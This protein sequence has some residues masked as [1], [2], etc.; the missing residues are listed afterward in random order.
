MHKSDYVKAQKIVKGKDVL[1]LGCNSGYGTNL[2]SQSCNRIVGVDVSPMALEVGNARYLRGNLSF[3]LVDGVSLPFGDQSFDV[4]TSFQVVEHLPEYSAYFNEIRRVLKP[5]GLLLLTTPNGAIRVNPGEKP[6][7]R[8]HVHEF[9]A[10]ELEELLHGYFPHV[11]VFGQFASERA[12]S[13]EFNRCVAA[14]DN[15]Y[16]TNST[17]FKSQIKKILPGSVADFFRTIRATSQSK[18]AGLVSDKFMAQFSI[19]DFSYGTSSLNESL[20]L[21]ACCAPSTEVLA[22]CTKIFCSGK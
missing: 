11:Q 4:V 20:S 3:K 10:V 22:D 15:I 2:L 12:Y 16:V 17:N 21:I 18:R 7:N 1:D 6:W 13:I 5:D 9:R 14:R 19:D 8:F